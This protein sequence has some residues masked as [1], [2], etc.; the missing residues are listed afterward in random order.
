M[1]NPFRRLFFTT[2]PTNVHLRL[3]EPHHGIL[4]DP[5]SPVQGP[6]AH[7]DHSRASTHFAPVSVNFPTSLSPAP[8]QSHW[9]RR[10]HG[11]L[12]SF[13]S[14]ERLSL[15][16]SRGSTANRRV[17]RKSLVKLSL[18]PALP[19]THRIFQTNNLGLCS[20]CT[21]STFCVSSNTI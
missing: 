14:R 17:Q 12:G 8:P 21:E 16:N 6:G 3:R 9:P 13:R 15:V 11:L 2:T 4:K 20:R 18:G 7:N 1:N 10:C 19:C 5:K